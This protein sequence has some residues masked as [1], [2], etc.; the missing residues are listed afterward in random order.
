MTRWLVERGGLLALAVLAFYLAWASPYVTE[1]DTAEF[2]TLGRVGGI[3]HPPGYPAYILWLRL[4]AWLPTSAA[5]GASIATALL[6]AAAIATLHAACRAWG[7]RPLAATCACGIVAVAPI[8]ARYHTSAEA[9]ALNNLVAALVLL[10]AARR[11]P[12]A[13]GS[14]AFALGLVAGIG[15]AGH[16]TCALLA[17]VGLLGVAR[18]AREHARPAVGLGLAVLGLALGLACYGYLFVAPDHA[19][20]WQHPATLDALLDIVLRREFGGPTAFGGSGSD[21]PVLAQL[22]ELGRTVGRTWLWVLPFVGVLVLV[23]RCRPRARGDADPGDGETSLAWSLLA[24]CILLAGPLLVTQ[25]DTP[26]NWFG[27]YIVHRFHLLPALLL[28][29]PIAVGLDA[30]GR[31]AP[32][33]R[34]TESP[35]LREG[36]ALVAC[37]ALAI[38]TVP[39]LA[40]FHSPAMERAVRNTL[41]TLPPDAVILG[42]IDEVDVG[43]HYLQLTEG[44]RRDV[45]VFRWDA[46]DRPWYRARVKL[47]LPPP[48]S[49]VVALA[50]A[51]LAQGRPVF[52]RQNELAITMKLPTYPY[53]TLL[54]VLPRGAPLPSL[55]EQLAINAVIYARFDLAYERPGP[56]A[57][58]ATMVHLKYAA[59][60]RGLAEQ[61]ARA[62]RAEE[63][64]LATAR[65]DELAPR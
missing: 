20:S 1:N 52:V 59:T 9:F 15:L 31:W 60:W 30:I 44:L 7:A 46:I 6:G 48:G 56:D 11:G 13:G 50:E 51:L 10:L 4:W 18:G 63:A 34:W 8:V 24:A 47:A 49:E 62:G 22:A 35:A 58:V 26:I 12:L 42:V 55:D 29:V 32:R 64:G 41:T 2:A 38:P 36:L 37:A 39:Y 53:G 33:R 43:A 19:Q 25:F 5:H 65:A 40:R 16:L 54:R 61:L 3:A 14:R 57:E 45:V 17:P 21:V 27:L 28:A 23:L